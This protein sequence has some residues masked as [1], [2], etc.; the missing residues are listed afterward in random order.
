M[1]KSELVTAIA[2]AHPSLSRGHVEQLVSIVFNEI[3]D[4]LIVGRRVELRGFGAFMLRNRRPK[5]GR[6]PRNGAAVAV[7]AKNQIYFKVGKYL[8]ERLKNS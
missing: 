8:R 7:L 2:K 5:M 1:I 6:N 4:A 3:R